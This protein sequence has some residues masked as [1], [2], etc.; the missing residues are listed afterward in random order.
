MTIIATPWL[1][2][3]LLGSFLGVGGTAL[4]QLARVAAGAAASWWAVVKAG[5][6]VA[7]TVAGSAKEVGSQ[8]RILLQGRLPQQTKCTVEGIDMNSLPSVV[9][10]LEVFTCSR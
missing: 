7:P 1:A 4:V 9:H 2:L 10:V 6:E 8:V 3:K 5:A